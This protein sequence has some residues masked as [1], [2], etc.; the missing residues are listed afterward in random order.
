MGRLFLT[1]RENTANNMMKVDG[2]GHARYSLSRVVSLDMSQDVHC[3]PPLE[4]R[5]LGGKD[6]K[7]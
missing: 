2:G 7:N 3:C 5:W 1:W 4:R 6:L